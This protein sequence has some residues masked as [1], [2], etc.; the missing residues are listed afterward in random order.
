MLNE[1]YPFWQKVRGMRYTQAVV[2]KILRASIPCSRCC[3]PL[4]TRADNG[5]SLSRIL[6]EGK[7]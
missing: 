2:W 7:R 5:G 6:H 1:Q 4:K 3:A